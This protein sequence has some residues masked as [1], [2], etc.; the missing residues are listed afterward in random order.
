[1]PQ[2]K[3]RLKY[4]IESV[5]NARVVKHLMVFAYLLF[6]EASLSYLRSVIKVCIFRIE[7]SHNTQHHFHI[8]FTPRIRF[9]G[10]FQCMVFILTACYEIKG[11]HVVFRCIIFSKNPSSKTHSSIHCTVRKSGWCSV[12][13]FFFYKFSITL[14][15]ILSKQRDKTVVCYKYQH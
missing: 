1:M 4:F 14:T 6:I 15:V 13:F 7:T 8:I 9:T 12:F 5:Y 2:R 11:M 3:R 10:L